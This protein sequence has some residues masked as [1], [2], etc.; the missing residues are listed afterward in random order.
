MV[1]DESTAYVTGGVYRE[2]VPD[3]RLVFAWGASDGWPKLDLDRLGDS[4]LVTVT[5]SR[6]N[7]GTALTLHVSLPAHLAEERVREWW[8]PAVRDGWQDTVD[9]L[10][11]R[12]AAD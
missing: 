10:A 9:R 2:I 4:P 1:I 12:L 5:L 7:G 11:A 6:D 8:S 3:E